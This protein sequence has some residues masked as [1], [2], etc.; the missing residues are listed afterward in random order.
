MT[1]ISPWDFCQTGEPIGG[2]TGYTDVLSS[3]NATSGYH[4][5]TNLSQSAFK[6]LV[7]GAPINTTIFIDSGVTIN[8]TG[9]GTASILVKEGITIASDRGVGVGALI[10]TNDMAYQGSGVAHPVFRVTGPNVRFT[11]FRFQGPYGGP[12]IWSLDSY[13][14]R[15]KHGIA[16]NYN[17]LIVDNMELYDWP[18]SAVIIGEWAGAPTYFGPAQWSNGHIYRYNYTHNNRQNRYGYGLNVQRAYVVAHHNLF[19]DNRHDI[20]SGGKS[21]VNGSSYE[22]Y[23]NTSLGDNRSHNFDVHGEQ[24]NVTG[25]IAGVYFNIHHNDFIDIGADRSSSGGTNDENIRISGNPQQTSI[26]EFNRFLHPNENEAIDILYLDAPANVQVNDNVYNGD[27][28]PG[29]SG[30]QPGITGL[31]FSSTGT[32]FIDVD[33]N[34]TN[35]TATIQ[36]VTEEVGQTYTYEKVPTGWPGP[37]PNFFTISGN[38]IIFNNGSS[39]TPDFENPQDSNA[40]NL[41]AFIVRVTASPSGSFYDENMHFTIIDVVEGGDTAVTGIAFANPNQ[42]VKIGEQVDRSIVFTPANPT[43]QNVAFSSDDLSIL[44]SN[45]I[46]ENKGSTVFRVVANDTTNG[47]IEATMNVQVV[48]VVNMTDKIYTGPSNTGIYYLGEIKSQ[49][50]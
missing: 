50:D 1:N 43:N 4:V 37:D 30:S 31:V 35:F 9:Q 15:L 42:I 23:C 5:T 47:T 33:E 45:G 48:S 27:T 11:G 46:G 22:A 13:D 7:E 41:Y 3:A 32:N 8:L 36:P 12:G 39:F 18:F 20:A 19:A 14:I 24:G 16:C 25:T 44:D 40:N 21:G 6:S 2:G 17:N 49:L 26:I 28:P 10:F 34:T 38:Q 29:Q